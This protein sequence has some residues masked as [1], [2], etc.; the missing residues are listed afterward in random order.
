MEQTTPCER[1][2]EDGPS[3]APTGLP[4][5]A[6]A[7]LPLPTLPCPLER[8]WGQMSA[9]CL[10]SLLPPS[11]PRRGHVPPHLH[12]VVGFALSW[13]TDRR[14]SNV[15][16]STAMGQELVLT[17]ALCATPSQPPGTSTDAVRALK[18]TNALGV[19]EHM[20]FYFTPVWL[21]LSPYCLPPPLGLISLHNSVCRHLPPAKTRVLF[22]TAS[23]S[24]PRPRLLTLGPARV[25]QYPLLRLYFSFPLQSNTHKVY[26][27]A[28]RKLQL[29]SAHSL[30]QT[31]DGPAPLAAPPG[32]WQPHSILT[33]GT[34]D[35]AGLVCI[36]LRTGDAE[37]LFTLWASVQLS[38]ACTAVAFK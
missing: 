4:W 13:L 38:G 1:H 34:A 35:V 6:L 10:P 24:P 22:P 3:P 15:T 21:F 8:A 7:A 9:F 29:R 18:N 26:I 33:K 27:P 32:P 28:L 17:E 16:L 31:P 20:P 12:I 5:G 37:H 23:L 14:H 2:T 36:S 11:P 30:F 19:G 25:L